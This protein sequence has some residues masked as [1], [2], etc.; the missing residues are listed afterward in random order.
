[1]PCLQKGKRL[2]SA[3]Q[4]RYTRLDG[5][6]SLFFS[7]SCF[8]DERTATRL[9]TGVMRRFMPRAGSAG[10]N[11]ASGPPPCQSALKITASGC[12]RSGADNS[13]PAG[14]R[15]G[16]GR[17][18]F[19]RRCRAHSS[20]SRTASR[21]WWPAPLSFTFRAGVVNVASGGIYV[22]LRFLEECRAQ[23]PDTEFLKITAKTT[24]IIP[25]KI[26]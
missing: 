19:R 17:R 4:K 6:A 8:H 22:C 2:A 9:P 7:R 1:M 23:Y 21:W 15:T 5:G 26:R 14:R 25:A 11:G 10:Y 24:M 18:K 13:S 12:G 3:M 16:T 20:C